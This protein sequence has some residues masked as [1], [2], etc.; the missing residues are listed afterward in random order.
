MSTVCS[1]ELGLTGFVAFLGRSV[2][3]AQ[4]LSVLTTVLSATEAAPRPHLVLVLADDLGWTMSARRSHPTQQLRMIS[5]YKGSYDGIPT[6]P[7]LR[8]RLPSMSFLLCV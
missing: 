2:L 6:T 3:I 5:S 1:S 7:Y 4:M 8:R